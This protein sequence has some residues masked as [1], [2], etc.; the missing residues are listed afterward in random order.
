MFVDDIDGLFPF[1]PRFFVNYSIDI[2]EIYSDCVLCFVI[3]LI[4]PRF[5]SCI[6]LSFDRKK[7]PSLLR[8]S[9]FGEFVSMG[10]V[11]S[12]DSGVTGID[13]DV[14]ILEFV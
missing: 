11:F 8:M 6:C 10:F 1:V 7:V 5:V 3:E 14:L 9:S 13:V 2:L 4:A 12:V